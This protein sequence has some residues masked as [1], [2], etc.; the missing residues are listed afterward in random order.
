M[1]LLSANNAVSFDRLL[2]A[3]YG[4]QLPPTARSQLQASISTLRRMFT[5]SDGA[6]DIVT[7]TY[8]YVLRVES[9]QLDAL[10]FAE[11]LRAACHARE[12]NQREAAIDRYRE[13]LRLWTAPALVDLDSQLVR[14]AA[15]RLDDRRF[16]AHEDLIELE[17]ESG[18]HHEVLGELSE[19]LARFPLRERL[20]GQLILALYRCG[21]P[22]RALDAYQRARDT[23][24]EQLGIEP[25]PRLQQLQRAILNSDPS[26]DLEAGPPLLRLAAPPSVN[27]L[28][29]DIGDF[30]GRSA[31]VGQIRRHLT[32]AAAGGSSPAVPVAVIT[33]KPGVGKTSIAVHA[34]HGITDQFPGGHLFADLRGRT[35]HPVSPRQVLE[36]FLRLLGVPGS[37]VPADLDRRVE[38]YRNVLAER[39]M[40]VVLDDAADEHQACPLLPGTGRSA[41]IIT[42]RR[43]LTGLPAAVHVEADIFDRDTS[44][45]LLAGIVGA[46]RVRAEPGEAARVATYCGNLPLALRIA[47]AR[48][49]ARPHWSV[50]QLAE[51]LADERH[52]LDELRHGSMGVRPGI[53]MSYNG[54]RA[55]AR[56]V[57]RLLALLDQPSFAGWQGAALANQPVREAEDLLDDLVGAQLIEVTCPGAGAHTR[58]RFH[59]L[60]RVFARERLAA[61]EPSTERKAAL[62]R[63]LGALLHL[64]EQASR[65]HYGGDSFE[66]H[67]DAMRWQL[68]EQVVENLVANPLSWYDL[69]SGTLVS[70]VRQ[71]AQAG[72][73]DL[74]CRLEALRGQLDGGGRRPVRA[75]AL[76]RN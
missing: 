76:L 42:S 69:E 64:A 54:A 9:S 73:A 50:R 15:T 40:L 28:P 32:G 8:G 56:R 10:R 29:T 58:Y 36:H 67:S 33:G 38:V 24:I 43:W 3:V 31:E 61:E 5:G 11:L 71:A 4:E 46:A 12:M 72:F 59:D 7:Q 13:A 2:E 26:L 1:L 17:L 25:S 34:A 19:L 52:R 70:A 14:A 41:V 45:E 37:R 18:R 62:E 47:G 39:R 60:T 63:A 44:V 49:S 20:H 66:L 68:P 35:T 6:A 16:T 23:L 75:P 21:R 48:L 65:R 55:E 53:S 74:S 30:T 22:A 57:F 27:L 51:R